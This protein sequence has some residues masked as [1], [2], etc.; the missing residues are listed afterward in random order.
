MMGPVDREALEH[1]SSEGVRAAWRD[2]TGTS[3]PDIS[4]A[5]LRLALA[6]ELQAKAHG[7][8]PKATAR[9]L[10]HAAA[11]RNQAPALRPGVRLVR[12]WNG[13]QHIVTAGEDGRP[14]WNGRSWNS[15]SEVAREITGVRW[16]GPAF[17]G[18]RRG[19]RV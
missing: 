13:V 10:A 6:W 18:L 14:I 9:R 7:G 19:R 4:P 15:L 16:S 17:F 12:E 1:L 8:I 3:P 5:L 2:A 11:G